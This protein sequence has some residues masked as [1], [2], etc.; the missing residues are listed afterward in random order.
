MTQEEMKLVSDIIDNQEKLV[1][2]VATH[3]QVLRMLAD[4]VKDL[5]KRLPDHK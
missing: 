2:S 5:Q 4:I 3:A 1:K